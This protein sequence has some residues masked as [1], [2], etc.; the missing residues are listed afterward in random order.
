MTSSTQVTSVSPS[1]ESSNALLRYRG[2]SQQLEE[3]SEKVD[4][5]A[6]DWIFSFSVLAFVDVRQVTAAYLANHHIVVHLQNKEKFSVPYSEG[7]LIRN[8]LTALQKLVDVSR[9]GIFSFSHANSRGF[10]DVRYVTAAYAKE[11]HIV[12]ILQKGDGFS[13]HYSEGPQERDGFI[14]SDFAALQNSVKEM[15][16]AKNS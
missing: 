7:P 16:R 14:Q 4:E 1:T 6:R 10:V 13:V 11:M 5:V 9:D 12:I 15:R 3:T 2:T 8:D